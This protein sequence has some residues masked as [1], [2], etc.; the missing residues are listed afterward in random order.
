MWNILP[1]H[2]FGLGSTHASRPGGLSI[3][4]QYNCA[5]PSVP[6]SSFGKEVRTNNGLNIGWML[7]TKPKKLYDQSWRQMESQVMKHWNTQRYYHDIQFRMFVKVY[8]VRPSGQTSC[9]MT[10]ERIGA[11]QTLTQ[12]SRKIENIW[13]RKPIENWILTFSVGFVSFKSLLTLLLY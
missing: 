3:K 13:T 11:L 7:I 5:K 6:G 8:V 1:C 12:I 2:N 9:N 10:S 4:A